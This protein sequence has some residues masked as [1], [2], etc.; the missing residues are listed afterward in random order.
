MN[1]LMERQVMM[2]R[3]HFFRRTGV[4]IGGAAL[5][6]LLSDDVPVFARTGGLPGLPHFAPRARRVIYLFQSVWDSA[7][8]RPERRVHAN[9]PYCAPDWITIWLNIARIQ[10][11]H[12]T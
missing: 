9:W 10:S 12:P 1:L 6:S 7:W 3:R 8:P 11:R 5:A 4:G 2:T